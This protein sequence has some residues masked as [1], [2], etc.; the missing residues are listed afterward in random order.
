VAG[1]VRIALMST[2]SDDLAAASSAGRWRVP[3]MLLMALALGAVVRFTYLTVFPSTV[4]ELVIAGDGLAYHLEANR[5]ADGLG[6]TSAGSYTSAELGYTSFNGDVGAQVAHHPPGWVTVLAIASWIGADSVVAH[7]VLT[8]MVGLLLIV[9]VHRVADRV[10]GASVATI[11]G[12]AAA[13]YPGFWV[14]EAQV[15]SEPL[16]LV[17]LGLALLALHGFA[18]DARVGTA[19]IAGAAV[20]AATLVRSEQILLLVVVAFLAFT[21]SG[22]TRRRRVLLPVVAALVVLVMLAPW[23]AFNATR[24]EDS[25]LLSS[26]SGTTLLGGNCSTFR[27]EWIGFYDDTCTFA[28]GF[29]AGP[30]DRSEMDRLARQEAI[31]NIRDNLGHLPFTIPAR[32]AR[33]LGVLHPAQTVDVVAAWHGT[34]AWPVWLWVVSYWLILPTAAVG[35]IA[36]RQRR[37]DLAGLVTP[38]VG[39]AIVVSVFYGEPRY[40]TPADL[41]VLILAAA[42]VYA[43]RR[44]SV[45]PVS[46]Q[47]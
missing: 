43:L 13:L 30:V 5:L 20:G 35:L 42:G 4:G 22:L 6:Y 45:R 28:L 31:G 14:L 33:M 18:R 26:N 25:V 36:V 19:L 39:V 29:S 21:A 41:S 11:A 9:V 32:H 15:L 16:A 7:Q 27:G 17:M 2:S 10:F 8:S 44:R 47:R 38:I 1:L 40:H 23:A 12:L 34:R 37:R 3:R 46:A 24:F